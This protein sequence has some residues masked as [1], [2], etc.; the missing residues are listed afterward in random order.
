MCPLLTCKFF[1]LFLIISSQQL[2]PEY[3]EIIKE[4]I[5]LKSICTKLRVSYIFSFIYVI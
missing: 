2:Y 3:Y 1:N 5:D 4:P